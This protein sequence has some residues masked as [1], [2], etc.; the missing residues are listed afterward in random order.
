MAGESRLARGMGT[1]EAAWQQVLG[2]SFCPLYS[3]L[4]AEEVR[5]LESPMGTDKKNPNKSLLPG[6]MPYIL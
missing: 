3:K 5:H 2:V 1:Q 6:A 4:I